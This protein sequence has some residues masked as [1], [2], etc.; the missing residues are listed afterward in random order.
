MEWRSDMENAPK[1]GTEILIFG[2]DI[3]GARLFAAY[4]EPGDHSWKGWHSNACVDGY[5]GLKDDEV[6]HWMPLPNP[7]SDR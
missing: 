6:T 3:G 2:H 5:Y 4:W 1:D 7:P